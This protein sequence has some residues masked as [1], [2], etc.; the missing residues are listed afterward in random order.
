MV[1]PVAIALA[2]ILG[3]SS[4]WADVIPARYAEGEA[5]KA[6]ETVTLR[7][8]AFGLSAAQASSHVRTLMDSEA[9]YFAADPNR[10]QVAGQEGEDEDDKPTGTQILTGAAYIGVTLMAMTVLALNH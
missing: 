10:V 3:A 9:L 7:M 2:L 8:Q 6:R 1:R 4:V 5:S